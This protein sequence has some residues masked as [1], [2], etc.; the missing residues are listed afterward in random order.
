VFGQGNSI[1]TG[2][3]FGATSVKLV[4]GA[5]RG[6]LDAVTHLGV[7][8]VAGADA[9][10]AGA[11]LR[12]LLDRLGLR[13]SQLGRIAVAAAG[14]EIACREVS[15]AAMGK[16]TLARAL[17]F[18]ARRHLELETM[19]QPVVDFQVLGTI[20]DAHGADGQIRV[21]FAAAPRTVRDFPVEALRVAGLEPDVVDLEPLA[22]LN[23]LAGSG[24]IAG[25]G[26]HAVGLLDL[27]S[28][29]AMLHVWGPEGGLLSREVGPAAGVGGG[30]VWSGG[31]TGAVRETIVFFRGRFRREVVHLYLTG[32]GSAAPGLVEALGAALGLDVTVF[33][34][35]PGL[36]LPGGD[37]AEGPRYTVACGLCRWWDST[38]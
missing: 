33:D 13:R 28:A 5:G 4:R 7:E 20:P 36:A 9:Q 19:V 16:D 11:A 30:D 26:E 38:H 17:P 34:P 2:I 6:R 25:V 23:A 15:V 31:L 24:A 14:P 35:L 21:L 37:T 22:A 12:R 10:A 3:D 32:G 29:R 1:R 18:E 8:P 27:G